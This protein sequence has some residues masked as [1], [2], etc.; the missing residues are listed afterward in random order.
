MDFC[1]YNLEILDSI[2]AAAVLYSHQKQYG[3]TLKLKPLCFEE[4]L[5]TRKYKGKV[6]VMVGTSLPMERMKTLGL[7]SLEFIWIDNF[8]GNFEDLISY[9]ELNEYEVREKSLNSYIKCFEVTKMNM[10]YY[11]SETLSSCEI[12][13]NF[14]AQKLGKNARDIVSCI[15]QYSTLRHTEETKIIKDKDWVKEVMPMYWF[16][17]SKSTPEQIHNILVDIDDWEKNID[18]ESIKSIGSYVLE[19]QKKQY[20]LLIKSSSVEFDFNDLKAIAINS[21]KLDFIAYEN[22]FFESIHDLVFMYFYNSKTCCWSI[23]LYTTK[24]EV[25]VLKIAKEF[26]GTGNKNFSRFNLKLEQLQIT[27]KGIVVGNVITLDI[28]QLPKNFDFSTKDIKLLL[29]QMKSMPIFI[30]TKTEKS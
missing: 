20:D 25:D 29:S 17:S 18:I 15:G 23:N 8:I 7:G 10:V 1:I 19:Y 27:K 3:D 30:E 14:Y 6:T 12:A 9:C 21:N 22:F 16:M 24:P 4:D 11:Y 26:G 13:I 2:T 5:D 28:D